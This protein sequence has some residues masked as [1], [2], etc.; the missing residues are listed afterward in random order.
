MKRKVFL[1]SLALL[2]AMGLVAVAYPA[3]A[4]SK[5]KPIEL[6]AS[7]PMPG[8]GVV[9]DCLWYFCDYVEKKTG[10]GVKFK[11]Y[12]SGQLASHNEHMTLIGTGGCHVTTLLTSVFPDQLHFTSMHHEQ[13]TDV[14]TATRNLYYLWFDCPETAPFFKDEWTKRNI[15]LLNAQAN[16]EIGFLLTKKPVKTLEDLKGIK[17][18][19]L[20]DDPY[21]KDF[22]M[23]SQVTTIP[24]IYEALARNQIQGYMLSASAFMMYKHYEVAK[25]YMDLG[26]SLVTGHLVMN[27]DAYKKLPEP[28]KRVFLEAGRATMEFSIPLAIREANKAKETFKNAGLDV[29]VLSK[30]EQAKHFK[31][32]FKEWEDEFYVR[33]KKKGLLD[34]S[35]TLVK[36]YKDLLGKD[37]FVNYP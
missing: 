11:R 10:G 30:E 16:G 22:G 35:K 29:S 18:G 9:A 33:A 2:F 32:F 3:Y 7:Y 27:L 4:Q 31:L 1:T 28:Y 13:L 8:T 37:M 5:D 20:T 17:M 6:I 14:E 21:M 23:H 19:T 24:D 36:H 12:P 25:T 15:L 26:L 34:Q